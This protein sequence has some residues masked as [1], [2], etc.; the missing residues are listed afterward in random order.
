MKYHMH[1]TFGAMHK[2]APIVPLN[3]ILFPLLLLYCNYVFTLKYLLGSAEPDTVSDGLLEMENASYFR[4]T[5]D[6]RLHEV[7]ALLQLLSSRCLSFRIIISSFFRCV[8]CCARH[9]LSM[10][11]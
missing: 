9:L 3:G 7:H 2:Q 6:D 5:E 8:E 1:Y 10:L 4:F 11:K